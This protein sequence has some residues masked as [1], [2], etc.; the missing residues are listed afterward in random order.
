MM[1]R[2]RAVWPLLA[3]AAALL[4]CTVVAAA[5]L[6]PSAEQ[7]QAVATTTTRRRLVATSPRRREA[8]VTF[9]AGE[10]FVLGAR[11]LGRSL[12]ETGTRR[13]ARNAALFA[14]R[15]TFN[16]ARA[17]ARR[18]LVCLVAGP[19]S[20]A[21][22]RALASSG[23]ALARVP[24]VANPARG[25]A[26]SFGAARHPAKLTHVYSKLAV[27]NLTAYSRVVYLDAD[28]LVVPPGADALFRCR[29]AL[30]AV[31]RHSERF[32]S[33]VM[34]LTPSAATARNMS[35]LLTTLPS[36]TGCAPWRQEQRASTMCGCA[37]FFAKLACAC[38]FPLSSARAR[39]AA[40][41][42]S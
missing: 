32:N 29:G 36:Y 26:A 38:V 21:S 1:R 16:R 12:Q 10:A 8:Y 14:M 35:A 13:C 19:L 4:A 5:A 25:D 20:R 24:T 28:T 31:M 3:C 40:T 33:G 34:V 41:R 30:C 39:T 9:V 2:A 7:V 42:A 27:F 15:F 17:R 23:W 18:A 11:V 37:C 22:T 6:T